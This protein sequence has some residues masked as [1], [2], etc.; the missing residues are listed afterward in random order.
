MNL[1]PKTG[2][3]AFLAVLA[4]IGCGGKQSGAV[5]PERHKAEQAARKAVAEEGSLDAAKLEPRSLGIT[6]FKVDPP[7]TALVA[8]GYGLADLLTTDLARSKGLQVVD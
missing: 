6:P 2:V 1:N 4:T 5:S 7:D 8:L 3:A